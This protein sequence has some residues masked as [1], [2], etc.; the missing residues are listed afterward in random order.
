MTSFVATGSQT[1]KSTISMPGSKAFFSENPHSWRQHRMVHNLRFFYNKLARICMI[2]RLFMI[3][4]CPWRPHEEPFDLTAVLS[5]AHNIAIKAYYSSYIYSLVHMSPDLIRAYDD[6]WRTAEQQH[7]GAK[8]C[9]NEFRKWKS[10]TR[11]RIIVSIKQS[12]RY[13]VHP[14]T[15]VAF[16]NY[17]DFSR[18]AVHFCFMF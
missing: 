3:R 15:G 13:L 10:S 2:F 8:W 7:R 12:T 4:R 14:H 6:G 5:V 11:T 9:H 16:S 17:Y 1:P 18:T